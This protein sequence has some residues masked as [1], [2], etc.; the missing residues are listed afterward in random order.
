MGEGYSGMG[1]DCSKYLRVFLFFNIIINKN[2][3]NPVISI[4]L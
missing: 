1:E 3:I 2:Y 4:A